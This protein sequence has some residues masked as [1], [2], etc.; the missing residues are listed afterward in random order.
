MDLGSSKGMDIVFG[1]GGRAFMGVNF[2]LN[3]YWVDN[4]C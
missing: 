4:P 1:F 3:T 2:L